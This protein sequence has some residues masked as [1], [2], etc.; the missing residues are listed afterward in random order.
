M[1]SSCICLDFLRL[2]I[3]PG[4]GDLD[5][6]EN[7]NVIYRTCGLEERRRIKESAQH[8]Q[9]CEMIYTCLQDNYG[10]E[11]DLPDEGN[12]HFIKLAT[13][14]SDLDGDEN[15]V[16]SIFL[17]CGIDSLG[18][19]QLKRKGSN[20]LFFAVWADKGMLSK[21][22]FLAWISPHFQ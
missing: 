13:Q 12:R 21:P 3:R 22:N 10:S 7:H 5:N 16:S 4:S 20:Y 19:T 9:L 2:P 18:R 6:G 1:E 11:F 15:R 8:C 17:E 14:S